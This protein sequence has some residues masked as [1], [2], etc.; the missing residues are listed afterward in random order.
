MHPGY[1]HEAP[2]DSAFLSV[3]AI[4]A[5]HY[6]QYGLK[7][8]K[9][10]IFLHGGPGG[11]TSSDNPRF[12]NPAIYRV[13]LF[14]QRGAG[15]S[16]PSAE[17]R[18]N[19][20]QLLVTDIESLRVHLGITKWHMVFGGSWGSMLA[21]MYAQAHP[22]MVGSLVL[23]GMMTGR[24]FEIDFTSQPSGA[25]MIYPEEYAAFLNHL[26]PE[27]R[28]DPFSGYYELLQSENAEIRRSAARAFG[29]WFAP[30]D[31][32]ETKPDVNKKLDNEKWAFVHALLISHYKV[33]K[34]FMEDGELLRK[35]NI[36]KIRR[37]PGQT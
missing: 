14:D 33:H 27:R 6:Q 18:N 16:T 9:P 5:L 17:I 36:E 4:H 3:D 31:R 32:V 22:E 26:Q 20:P 1:H 11:E 2:F 23:R 35:E 30:L 12:F 28:H 15:K 10:V 37:I 34:Y 7:T 21:L 8:G 13:V 24:Q 25:A 29:L 19:T